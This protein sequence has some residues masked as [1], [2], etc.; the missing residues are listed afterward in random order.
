MKA[1]EKARTLI[2]ATK[3]GNRQRAI[4]IVMMS[5]ILYTLIVLPF[6]FAFCKSLLVFDQYLY[7]KDHLSHVVGN[8]AMA[9]G[10]VDLNEI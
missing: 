8:S 5:V 7:T 4:H 1:P 3:I 10:Y 6:Q 2:E 9:S